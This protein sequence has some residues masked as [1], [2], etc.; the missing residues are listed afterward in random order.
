VNYRFDPGP[1]WY[2]GALC[3]D[4][5]YMLVVHEARTTADAITKTN[6]EGNLCMLCMRNLSSKVA[7]L[8]V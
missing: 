6:R 5:P 1:W 8:E 2:D 7:P 3:S 4:V